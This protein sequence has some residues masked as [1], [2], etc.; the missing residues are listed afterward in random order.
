MSGDRLFRPR[1]KGMRDPLD[2]NR[3]NGRVVNP[4]RYAQLG[5]LSSGKRGTVKNDMVIKKPGGTISEN[6]GV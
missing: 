4:P 2:N 3:R 6:P 1:E 5:G